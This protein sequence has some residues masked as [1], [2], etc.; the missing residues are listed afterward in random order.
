MNRTKPKRKRPT[1]SAWACCVLAACCV[2]IL[3]AGGADNAGT[4]REAEA[5]NAA[6]PH[7]PLLPQACETDLALSAAPAH[8]RDDATIYLLR[9]AG[10]E[11]TRSGTNGFTCIVNRDDPRVLKPTCFDEEGAETIVPKILFFG[12][13]MMAG[14]STA[15]I[16][17]EV[18]RGFEEGTFVRARR[19]GV[20]YMLSRYNRPV[21][22]QTGKRGWF[23]PHVMFYAPDLTNE[24]IGHD[25]STDNP[26]Q[27]LP[28]IGYQGPHGYMIMISDDG[29]PRSRDD[30]RGCPDWVHAD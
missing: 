27:P 24:D 19:P 2:G 9:D 14:E 26:E 12:R 3:D 11:R 1:V 20:A 18:A 22:P 10:Y 30:L 4:S 23:P 17:D 21:N 29:T 15:S 6:A 7:N 25:M 8:L 5:P 28:M 16:R 13:R